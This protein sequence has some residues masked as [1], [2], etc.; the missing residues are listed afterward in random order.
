MFTMNDKSKVKA[1]DGIRR[2]IGNAVREWG[3]TKLARV[4]KIDP[5]TLLSAIAAYPVE[6]GRLKAIKL[7]LVENGFMPLDL[8]SMPDY[9]NDE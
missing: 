7:F 3:S 6:Y 2:G 8:Q 1:G 4:M 9:R 5:R